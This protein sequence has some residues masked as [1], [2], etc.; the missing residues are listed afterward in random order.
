MKITHLLSSIFRG[1]WA[2]D[3]V[4]A[5]GLYPL[6]FNLL[7]GKLDTEATQKKPE[8][9][10]VEMRGRRGGS[11]RSDSEEQFIAILE[12]KDVVVKYDQ[13][14]GPSGTET[15]AA[16]I[17]SAANDA[18]AA[19]III[20]LDTPGGEGG[21]CQLPSQA[22]QE[23]RKVKP[24]IAYLGNGMCAS[25][26]YYIACNADE[27]YATFETDEIG[28]IG[29][30]VTIADFKAYYESKGLKIED[31]YAS[32]STNKNKAYKL[33]LEGKYDDLRKNYIDPFNQVFLD[34]VMENR[35]I[36][37]DSEALTGKLYYAE[38][39]IEVGLIDGI[40]TFDQ[41]VE[42]AFELADNFKTNK[43]N[44]KNSKTMFGKF[45]ALAAFAKA[46]AEDRTPEQLVAVNTEL[47]DAGI[48]GF[49]MEATEDLSS[50]ADVT[51]AL[52]DSKADV[53]TANTD[54]DTAQ[55]EATR[56]QGELTT[57]TGERDTAQAR[58]AELEGESS[59]SE[60]RQGAKE[61][62]KKETD[63]SAQEVIDALPHNQKADKI[64]E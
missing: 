6:V 62:D 45:K 50:E 39:A 29:T 30:Y 44:H 34:T 2:I 27:L 21:A 11:T 38:D 54:R 24:V 48:D 12:Y 51:K 4:K 13:Y 10:S 7:D 28:S 63:L 33:A 52:A 23:A 60:G 57:A 18:S 9:K 14:C 32:K 26:G 59:G 25:A 40:K 37:A 19:A 46:D 47:K 22:I 16:M 31:V 41:V 3:P 8:I 53:N 35:G 17:N 15:L 61:T 58:V 20:D 43:S 42:R 56:L 55:T 49:L 36:A 1:V 5:E 64:L